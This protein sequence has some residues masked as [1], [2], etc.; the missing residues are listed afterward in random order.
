MKVQNYRSERRRYWHTDPYQWHG[1]SW[2][3]QK[4]QIHITT[5][6]IEVVVV[7]VIFDRQKNSVCEERGTGHIRRFIMASPTH[8]TTSLSG[9][10]IGHLSNGLGSTNWIPTNGFIVVVGI[11]ISTHILIEIPLSFYTSKNNHNRYVVTKSSE[12]MVSLWTWI[13]ISSHTLTKHWL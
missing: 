9:K 3:H 7:V 10:Q 8:S 6:H 5:N 11:I 13:P 1:S 12:Y 2:F 4:T